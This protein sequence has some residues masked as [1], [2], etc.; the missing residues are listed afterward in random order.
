M[1]VKLRKQLNSRDLSGDLVSQFENIAWSTNTY[2]RSLIIEKKSWPYSI[3]VTT[4]S[5]VLGQQQIRFSSHGLS[6]M[7]DC[8]WMFFIRQFYHRMILLTT[9]HL[10]GRA[11]TETVCTHAAVGLHN[12]HCGNRWKLTYNM[13]ALHVFLAT[14][15]ACIKQLCILNNP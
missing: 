4:V 15:T 8:N 7:R 3:L 10:L 13:T 5:T 2:S 12:I 14:L 6:C 9:F 1:H 11:I